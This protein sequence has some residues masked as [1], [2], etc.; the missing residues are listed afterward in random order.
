METQ[1]FLSQ[2]E[3]KWFSQRSH[4][5]FAQ[6][7]ADNHKSELIVE[8]LTADDTEVIALSRDHHLALENAI[9]IFKMAWDTS[10]DWGKPKQVGSLVY[11]FVPE[12]ENSAKGKILRSAPKK[13]EKSL[14]G[15]YN[16][17][18]DESLTLTFED[19][20]LKMEERIWFASPNLRMR[21]SLILQNEQFI[22]S[23]FYSEIRKLP[24][25][26]TE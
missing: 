22:H 23:A 11:L 25:T 3:G 1:A 2:W 15:H 17:A 6:N 10:V 19:G 26:K 18:S 12:P 14:S 7:I 13:G 16:L 8:A 5:D 24:P 4:Y 21:T 20:T 9:A